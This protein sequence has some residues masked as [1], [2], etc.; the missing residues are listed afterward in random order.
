MSVYPNYDIQL[1]KF[2]QYHLMAYYSSGLALAHL[3]GI[4]AD[5]T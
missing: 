2:K 1:D 3:P 5:P 4:I